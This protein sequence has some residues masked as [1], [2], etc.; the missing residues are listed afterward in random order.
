MTWPAK[1]PSTRAGTSARPKADLSRSLRGATGGRRVELSSC[2]TEEAG[3]V[4]VKVDPKRTSM[5]CSACGASQ[6]DTRR[7]RPW[8][9][10][11]VVP[12]GFQD[13][14]HHV[15]AG[16][17]VSVLGHTPE[18]VAPGIRLND[19]PLAGGTEFRGEVLAAVE[20][21]PAEIEHDRNPDCIPVRAHR[22][23]TPELF[24]VRRLGFLVA[25]IRH[26]F[27]KDHFASCGMIV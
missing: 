16:Q 15:A 10:S 20:L 6:P 4:A 14:P 19:P 13:A 8:R 3:G 17:I 18:L 23:V 12:N 24:G 7:L 22:E 26:F 2:R 25:S 11:E 5:A 27:P 1:G 9:L 21:L